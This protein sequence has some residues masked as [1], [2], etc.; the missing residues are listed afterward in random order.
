MAMRH[1]RH[2]AG[3]FTRPE[4]AL[5]R[6]DELEAVGQKSAALQTLHDVLTSKKH[7][8]WSDV[9]EKIVMRHTDLCVDMKK[10]NMAKEALMQFRNMAHSA[11]PNS[12]EKVIHYFL[13]RAAEKAEEAQAKATVSAGGSRRRRRRG[14]RVRWQLLLLP[15]GMVVACQIPTRPGA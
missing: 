1:F 6:A 9:Y 15:A 5:K 8:Q 10:R 3:G 13:N 4:N 7:R 2:G 11:A 14:G 12:L